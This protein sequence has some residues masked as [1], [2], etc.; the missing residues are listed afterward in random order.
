[1]A[2]PEERNAV[3]RNFAF[4]SA[5]QAVTYLLPVFI[6]PYLFRVIGPDKFGLLSFAQ[7]FIQ[8]FLILTDYGFNVSATKEISVSHQEPEMI[9]KIFHGVYFRLRLTTPT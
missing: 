7:A 2:E 8:Y 1:M 9:N 4:L 3:L 5:L 6:L